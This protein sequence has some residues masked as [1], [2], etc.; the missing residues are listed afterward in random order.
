MQDINQT[1]QQLFSRI[2]QLESEVKSLKLENKQIKL[3]NTKLTKENKKLKDENIKLKEIINKDSTNSSKPPSTDN[4]FKTNTTTK[5]NSKSDKKRGGQ[6]GSSTTNLSKVDNPDSIEV[7]ESVTCKNCNHHLGTTAVKSISVRQE[8]DIPKISMRVTEF[9]Q[10]SKICPCCNT[11]NKPEFPEHL[12]ASVQYGEN[13]KTFV[14]Y[15]NTYQMIP[16]DRLSELIKDFTSHSISNGTI[17]T[18]LKSFYGKLEPYEANIK[19]LLLK[20]NV[21]HADETG[22]QVADKLHWTHTVSTSYLT[23]YMIHQKRGKEAI[24][25][26]GILPN[27]NGI[28]VHDHWQAYNNYD[29]DHSFCNAHL[30]RELTAVIQNEDQKW[31]KDMH[32][33]LTNMNKYIYKLKNNNKTA[34]SKGKLKHFFS[35]YRE[36]CWVALKFYPPPIQSAIKRR[37]KQSKSKN[38]LDRLIKYKKETLRFFTDL[39]VPFT[40]NLAERDLRMIKVKEKISGCFASFNG[41]QMFNRIRGFISTVKKNKQSVFE[42]LRNAIRG[43]VYVPEIVGC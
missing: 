11:L 7:L 38:L 31:A 42:S 33:L 5:K 20:S 32:S 34:P 40:N 23:Y 29:C 24:D 9:Q 1:L 14:A 41:A 15:L 25:T 8:F 37:P 28:A 12:K 21:I 35:Q 4:N 18:M 36:I 39:R 2:D 10:H 19:Q 6:K 26:M 13:I 27:Y 17:N 16:Y 43:D 22:T 30:L 3:E